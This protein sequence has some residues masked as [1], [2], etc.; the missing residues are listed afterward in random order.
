V[1]YVGTA[2]YTRRIDAYDDAN[3]PNS[4]TYT[5]PA[6]ETRIGGS[7]DA[8]KW[9]SQ[10]EAGYKSVCIYTFGRSEDSCNRSDP[11]KK[12]HRPGRRIG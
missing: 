4:E 12:P 2:S 9:A 10:T 7:M 1:R 11:W 8:L 6:T 5:I 3:R